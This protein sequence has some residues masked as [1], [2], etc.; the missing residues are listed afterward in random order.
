MGLSVKGV[1]A[2]T[3]AYMQRCFV[4]N[5]SPW[6]GLQPESTSLNYQVASEASSSPAAQGEILCLPLPPTAAVRGCQVCAQVTTSDSSD[7]SSQS[8]QGM[9]VPFKP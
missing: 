4:E 6:G 1:G 9:R 8:L 7:L 3:R 5:L 2:L